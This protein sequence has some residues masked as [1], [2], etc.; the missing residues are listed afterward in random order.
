MRQQERR[1]RAL[2]LAAASAFAFAAAAAPAATWTP[3]VAPTAG[4]ASVQP[5]LART[6]DG[7]LHVLWPRPNADP[8]FSDLLHV[9]VP[10]AGAT[11]PLA[12]TTVL[13][14]WSSLGTA[15]LTVSPAGLLAAINGYQ[16]GGSET[17]LSTA[18]SADGGASW[19]I[20][21]TKVNGGVPADEPALTV[22]A[23]G[24]PFFAFGSLFVHRGL[25]RDGTAT[26]Y[27][28]T[29]GAPAPSCC[30]YDPDITADAAGTAVWLQ[31]Y[32]SDAAKPGVW[33]AP[34]DPAT[35]APAGSAV[36]M[37]GSVVDYKGTPIGTEPYGRAAVAARAG[38]T[39]VYGVSAGGYPVRN[40][41]LI[42]RLGA[43]GS[44]LLSRRFGRRDP[45]R[46][47][48][49]AGAPD[50]RMWALWSSGA[51]D[52]LRIHV[53]RSNPAGTRWGADQVLG[54]LKDVG[55]AQTLDA[56]PI[57]GALDVV[58]RFSFLDA[59]RAG[60][61]YIRRVLPAL[62]V[63]VTSGEI[64]RGRPVKLGLTV[65]DAGAPVRGVRLTIDQRKGRDYRAGPTDAR[66]RASVT[67]TLAGRATITT[68]RSGYA[69]TRS[70]L[71][72]G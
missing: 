44:T 30:G 25:A 52:S 68:H 38:G 32:S 37:P 21:L 60:T 3:L 18:T 45:I 26:D 69:E 6:P 48:T 59:T 22:T 14:H 5:G 41:A 42:W 7:V 17:A 72:P 16:G 61:P 47:M 65:T 19:A 46:A 33:A 36:R 9:A 31:W 34:V 70:P 13:E 8:S 57:G 40:K 29:L 49:V 27:Q 64:R 66:G 67:V 24:T 4:D 43:D 50:G 20:D 23:D 51:F 55:D 11:G 56:S 15:D 54:T 1:M 71:A 2:S 58:G 12:P 28:A 63:D 39:D 35:G 62:S 53:R 10:A